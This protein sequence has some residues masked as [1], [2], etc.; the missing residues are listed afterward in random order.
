MSKI[1]TPPESVISALQSFEE[2][3][4]AQRITALSPADQA[5]IGEL[6]FRHALAGTD[7]DQALALAAVE[8]VEGH[9]RPLRRS[10]RRPQSEV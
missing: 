5:R 4:V 2:E 9:A 7:L 10:G 1:N 3:A 6:A 8:V